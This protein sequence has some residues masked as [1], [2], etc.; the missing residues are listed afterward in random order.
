MQVTLFFGGA[1]IPSATGVLMEV[2][3]PEARPV[4]SA[5]SMFAFQT[6]GYAMAPLVSALVMQLA[7]DADDAPA[8]AHAGAAPNDTDG[9]ARNGTE[10]AIS[11][12]ALSAAQLRLGFRTVMAWGLFGVAFLTAAWR[13]AERECRARVGQSML[14]PEFS[15]NKL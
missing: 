5:G 1:I 6:F 2:A 12:V 9:G 11:E 13:E 3:A 8:T 14:A 15:I 7:G 4:A 10:V